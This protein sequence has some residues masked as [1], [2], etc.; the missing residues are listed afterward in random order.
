MGFRAAVSAVAVSAAIA[1]GSVTPASAGPIVDNAELTE[2]LLQSGDAEKAI[3]A[4]HEA[5]AAAWKESPLLV[6][7][8]L[9]VESSSGLGIYEPRATSSY[10]P[11]DKVQLY[12]EPW[13][14]GYGS[15]GDYH[16]IDL[17]LGLGIENAT[18]QVLAEQPDLFS[19]GVKTRERYR[20]FSVA[21]TFVMPDLKDGDYV[22]A[23][24]LDDLNSP[25]TARFSVPV[26]VARPA[27]GE[28]P[29]AEA[30]G[31]AAPSDEGTAAQ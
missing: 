9:L 8:A 4:L 17:K 19:V 10:A 3:E 30:A 20:D 12:V 1:F 13:G 23:F 11:G 16:S 6:R 2:S 5:V 29:V 25:K 31:D 24:A 26:N 28:N 22:L 21:L 14:F 7:E 18:G 15:S 27:E